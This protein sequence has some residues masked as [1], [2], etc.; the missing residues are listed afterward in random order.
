MFIPWE[1]GGCREKVGSLFPLWPCQSCVIIQKAMTEF[2]KG[3]NLMCS[4]E[5]ICIPLTPHT[6][7]E[8]QNC[9]FHPFKMWQSRV[10]KV[11]VGP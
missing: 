3:T 6:K 11:N 8:E 5:K 4:E 2:A 9:V 7:E 1:R 10:K